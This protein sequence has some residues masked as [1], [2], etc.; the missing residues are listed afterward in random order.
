MTGITK[1]IIVSFVCLLSMLTLGI[2]AAAFAGAL[3][4]EDVYKRQA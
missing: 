3:P 2:T 1:K 4:L